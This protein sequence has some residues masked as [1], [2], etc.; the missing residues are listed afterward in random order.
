[1]VLLIEQEMLTRPI[2][3]KTSFNPEVPTHFADGLDILKQFYVSWTGNDVGILT[4]DPPRESNPNK[5]SSHFETWFCATFAYYR[6]RLGGDSS[7]LERLNKHYT[8]RDL[9]QVVEQGRD[10]YPSFPPAI[11]YMKHLLGDNGAN[12]DHVNNAINFLGE[13]ALEPLNY[14]IGHDRLSRA[15]N[16]LIPHET[17]RLK[18]TDQL[19][20]NFASTLML[21]TTL[22]SLN[23]REGMALTER[24]DEIAAGLMREIPYRSIGIRAEEINVGQVSAVDAYLLNY[25][26]K[27]FEEEIP[28]VSTVQLF[29]FVLANG[30][31][32]QPLRQGNKRASIVLANSLHVERNSGHE[33][34]IRNMTI[35]DLMHGSDQRLTQIYSEIMEDTPKH[36]LV[37]PS[38]VKRLSDHL[39]SLKQVPLEEYCASIANEGLIKSK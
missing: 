11:T 21:Q 15:F 29:A 10:L 36:E 9:D 14:G 6:A 2:G 28:K 39:N 24:L 3:G 19:S 23:R 22:S 5:I 1:M 20:R 8:P 35:P 31:H 32:L 18:L 25:S 7:T 27:K 33:F 4:T 16:L 12:Q 17:G 34:R 30:F 13:L 38:L 37:S 26:L